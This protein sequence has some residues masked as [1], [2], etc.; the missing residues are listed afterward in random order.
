[1]IYNVARVWRLSTKF[2][3][4]TCKSKEDRS[5]HAHCAVAHLVVEIQAII[6]DA[7]REEV[8]YKISSQYIQN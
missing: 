4:D 2:Q 3:V 8:I 7:A 5:A 6:Y 1:M